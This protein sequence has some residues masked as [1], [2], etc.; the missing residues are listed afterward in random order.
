MASKATEGTDLFLNKEDIIERGKEAELKIIKFAE[1]FINLENCL[2]N[3]KNED[4]PTYIVKENPCKKY[5]HE[6]EKSDIMKDYYD[7]VNTLQRHTRCSLKTCYR[8]TNKNKTNMKC[9][10]NFPKE[11]RNKT[12]LQ[13]EKKKQQK[14]S[15]IT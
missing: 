3:T 2:S 12:I 6:I 4:D 14:I 1:T 9:R 15:R 10:Y 5:F 8:Y 7:L 11:R 13:F